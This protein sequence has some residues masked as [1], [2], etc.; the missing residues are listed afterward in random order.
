[1]TSCSPVFICA[2]TMVYAGSVFVLSALLAVRSNPDF[3]R[4]VMRL[5]DGSDEVAH[6]YGFLE[7]KSSRRNTFVR[8]CNKDWNRLHTKAACSKLGFA[9]G[10]GY[11][12]RVDVRGDNSPK[13]IVLHDIMNERFF[14][15]VC[16]K[17]V[18]LSCSKKPLQDFSSGI[19]GLFSAFP[20]EED[21]VIHVCREEDSDA[22]AALVCR[23]LGFDGGYDHIFSPKLTANDTVKLVCQ[24]AANLE[25][26]Q[27][28]KAVE[29][30]LVVNF[31]CYMNMTFILTDMNI[32][33]EVI[34]Y[35]TGD[36]INIVKRLEKNVAYHVKCTFETNLGK[37][38]HYLRI[39][40]V[41]DQPVDSIEGQDVYSY[42]AQLGNCSSFYVNLTIKK[43]EQCRYLAEDSVK[44]T[45]NLHHTELGSLS[46]DEP[47]FETNPGIVVITLMVVLI[48]FVLALVF[49]DWKPVL[50]QLIKES[51]P[52]VPPPSL[53]DVTDK[54]EIHRDFEASGLNVHIIK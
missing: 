1:M 25:D 8:I 49:G 41:C 28:S 26:C 17:H 18:L 24:E 7:V 3:S 11:H 33:I 31:A 38:L 34:P 9:D 54:T 2:K 52:R 10:L 47:F 50:P 6:G 44:I 51:M 37:H 13:G 14:K 19:P 43:S 48:L 23:H 32:R 30:C 36:T 27:S 46:N 5:S 22:V 29:Q 12:D 39:G 35:C 45:I 15:K 53:V 42:S 21:R 4:V 40:A 16:S 20:F